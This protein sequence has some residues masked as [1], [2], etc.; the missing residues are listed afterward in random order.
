MADQV[1]A[2][3]IDDSQFRVAMELFDKIAAV[4]R[5]DLHHSRES[6]RSI[7]TREWILNTYSQCIHATRGEWTSTEDASAG[8]AWLQSKQP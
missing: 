1:V 7:A 6:P 3:H 4:E 5:V 2:K 8:K